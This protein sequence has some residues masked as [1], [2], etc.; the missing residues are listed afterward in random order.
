M[1]SGTCNHYR[2]N[3]HWNDDGAW[4]CN[5][6][7]SFYAYKPGLVRAKMDDDRDDLADRQAI[8]NFPEWEAGEGKPGVLP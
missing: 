5:A 3:G 4:W 8:T 7:A 2:G 1:P 6:C